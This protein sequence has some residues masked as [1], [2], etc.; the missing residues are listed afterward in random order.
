MFQDRRDAGRRLAKLLVEEVSAVGPGPVVVGLARGGLPVATEVAAALHAP[1]D[2]LVARKLGVPG[3]PELGMG[4]IAEGGGRILNSALIAEAG[5][6]DRAIAEVHDREQQELKRR[7]ERYRAGRAPIPVAGRTVILVDDGLATGYTAWAAILAL[8]ARGAERVVLAVPV[9]PADT[10][11]VLSAVADRVVALEQPDPFMAIGQF[12][13][14]FSQTSDEEVDRL[15]SS[16]PGP[17]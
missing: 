17:P 2:V 12:Y 14:D 16:S 13:A 3:Q 5:V 1:L 4:A 7:V 8:R 6:D 9:A 11:R 15:L 10:I